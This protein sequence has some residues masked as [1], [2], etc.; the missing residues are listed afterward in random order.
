MISITSY[1]PRQERN[2]SKLRILSLLSIGSNNYNNSTR[3][4]TFLKLICVLYSCQ[5]HFHAPVYFNIRPFP[6]S[7]K[8]FYALKRKKYKYLLFSIISQINKSHV[9]NSHMTYEFL[10]SYEMI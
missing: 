6:T 7:D 1:E 4:R 3:F 2:E 8:I 5:E 10:Y 9:Y